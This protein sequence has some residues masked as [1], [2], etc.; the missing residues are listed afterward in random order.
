VLGLAAGFAVPSGGAETGL[1][2]QSPAFA[3]GAEI[4]RRHTCQGEDLSPPLSWT[5]PPAGTRS[6]AL[7][8]DDP[9][10]PDPR[11]PKKTWVHWVVVG[12]PPRT[13]TLAEGAGGG[14]LPAGARNGLNDFGRAD[15]GGPCPPIGRHR[16]VHK[17]YALDVE[18]GEL[19]SPTKAELERAMQGHVLAQ[20]ELIGTYEKQP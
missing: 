17:L 5:E 10:A 13:R 1:R 16:Y 4:P 18:L 15:W 9:D 7:V 12:I 8:V 20:A 3:A 14:Q 19:A 6:F 2:L 11:A